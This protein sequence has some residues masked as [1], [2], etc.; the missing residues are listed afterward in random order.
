MHHRDPAPRDPTS[1]PDD[2]AAS[3]L[4]QEDLRRLVDLLA[5]RSYREGDFVLASGARSSFYL[6]AKQVTYHPEGLPLVARGVLDAV[7]PFHV[8]AVGGLTMGADP[9]VAGTVAICAQVGGPAL[10]GFVVRKEP[11]GHGTGRWIEGV[12]EEGWPAAVL[13]DVVTSGGSSLKAVERAREHGA[14][15][16][17]VVAL[18]D[19]GEGGRETVEAAGLAYRAVTDLNEIRASYE[20]GR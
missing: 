10:T 2:A 8:R 19:R 15:V 3:F 17:A 18:V 20:A 14:D 5:Q 9:I 4:P 6:D 7:T 13:D 11:K 12:L 1:V 16:R